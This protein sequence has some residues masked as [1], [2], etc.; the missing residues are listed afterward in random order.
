MRT[1]LFL[2]MLCAATLLSGCA[3]DP[4]RREALGRAMGQVGT[5][6]MEQSAPQPLSPPTQTRCRS[7]GQPDGSVETNCTS[8]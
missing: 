5:Q 7:T 8:Y 2:T 3:M 4:A 6:M 1:P